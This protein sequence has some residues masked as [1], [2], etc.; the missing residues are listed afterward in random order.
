MRL[1]LLLLLSYAAGQI[2]VS[3]ILSEGVFSYY[4][5]YQSNKERAQKL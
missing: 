1:I 4:D 2:K 5:Y 3:T